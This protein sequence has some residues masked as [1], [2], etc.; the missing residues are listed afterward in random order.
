MKYIVYSIAISSLVVSC[1]PSSN[2]SP[3]SQSYE[4]RVVSIEELEQKNPLDFLSID[5]TYSENFFGNKINIDCKIT[6]KAKVVAYKDAVVLVTYFSKTKTAL[7]KKEFVIY[8]VLA[9]NSTKSVALKVDNYQDVSTI[10]LEIVGAKIY[11]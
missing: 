1:K 9:A 5:G 11:K 3:N 8:E 7:V 6:N 4:Q 2:S 10:D